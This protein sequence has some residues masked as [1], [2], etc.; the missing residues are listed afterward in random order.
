M[1]YHIRGKLIAAEPSFAVIEAG[2]VGYKLTISNNTREALPPFR[3]VKEAPEVCLLT[4]FSVRED[5]V[6]LFGFSTQDELDTFRLLTSVS[7]IGPK[8]AISILSTLTP[9]KLAAA[10]AME[11]KRSISSAN[12]IGPKTAAR[13]ILELKDKLS[14]VSTDTENTL[15]VSQGSASETASTKKNNLSEAAEALA[16][17]GYSKPEIHN[18]LKNADPSLS[19]DAIIRHALSRLL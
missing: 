11:D 12:G 1:F 8:A 7:G 5:G 10:V 19:T 18:A 6:E 17:L 16:A 3:S 13:L 9:Q 14:F 4:H 2:G 15:S